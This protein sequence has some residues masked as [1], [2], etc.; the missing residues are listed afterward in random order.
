MMRSLELIAERRAGV[1]VRHLARR[2]LQL[3]GGIQLGFKVRDVRGGFVQ[4]VFGFL[5]RLLQPLEPGLGLLG[6]VLRDG[7]LGL[8]CLLGLDRGGEVV[9]E[10]LR[11]LLAFGVGG[12]LLLE[13]VDGAAERLG[14]NLSLGRSL[15]HLLASRLSARL[16]LLSARLCL[17]SLDD[18][19][20]LCLLSLRRAGP[21]LRRLG[22]G[23]FHR[24]FEFV[25]GLL[26]GGC[27]VFGV[28]DILRAL[29]QLC[30][31][32]LDARH[33]PLGIFLSLGQGSLVLR[34]ELTVAYAPLPLL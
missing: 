26:R 20:R 7:R 9:R 4:L 32:L 27:K 25:D 19:G 24:L 34:R 31:E 3:R 22:L 2:S 10:F 12:D 11:I 33:R 29:R 23:R 8:G 28:L 16:C 6:G 13:V 21:S 14:V 5:R 30:L 17:V 18:R 15:L 1:L